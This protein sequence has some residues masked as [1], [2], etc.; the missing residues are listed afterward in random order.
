M[1]SATS[2]LVLALD[3]GSTR[4]GTPRRPRTPELLVAL[5]FPSLRERA[6]L[7][8]GRSGATGRSCTPVSSLEG[9]RQG[10]ARLP[11][12]RKRGSAFARTSWL[13]EGLRPLLN[14]AARCVLSS[15]KRPLAECSSRRKAARWG[16]T[17]SNG[18]AIPPQTHF[19]DA[20]SPRSALRQVGAEPAGSCDREVTL[21]VAQ[22]ITRWSRARRGCV[23]TAAAPVACELRRGPG[24]CDVPEAVPQVVS[25]LDSHGLQGGGQWSSS[26]PSSSPPASAAAF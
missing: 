4:S 3:Q 12:R 1:R 20:T 15:G 14:Q 16:M 10:G 11:R 9:I 13:A 6:A 18:V 17:T 23:S 2:R 25:Q 24:A 22:A 26:T 19:W 5:H 7:L 21:A 8:I